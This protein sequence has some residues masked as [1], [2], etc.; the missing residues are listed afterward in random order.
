MNRP[1]QEKR[2]TFVIKSLYLCK[3]N[4]ITKQNSNRIVLFVL[5]DDQMKECERDNKPG[6]P[7]TLFNHLEKPKSPE[8]PKSE[9]PNEFGNQQL[10]TND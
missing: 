7:L 6:F 5:L 2:S 3:T 4:H 8:S 10:T 1:N 9:K